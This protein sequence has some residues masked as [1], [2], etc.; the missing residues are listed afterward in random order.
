M[1]TS[2]YN[3]SQVLTKL[4]IAI[5]PVTDITPVFKKGDAADKTNDRPISTL[6]NFSKVFEKLIYAQIN[7]F[8]ELKTFQISSRFPSKT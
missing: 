3:Y 5:T 8:M 6:P 4:C 7:S 2:V 1:V